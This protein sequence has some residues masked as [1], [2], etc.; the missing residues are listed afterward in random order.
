VT[1]RGRMARLGL[2]LLAV[3]LVATAAAYGAE[4]RATAHSAQTKIAFT[5]PPGPGATWAVGPDGS[6]PTKLS[7]PYRRTRRAELLPVWSPDGR[8]IAFTGYVGTPLGGADYDVYVMDADGGRVRNLTAGRLDAPGNFAWSPD[9][10]RLVL[11]AFDERS[12]KT[13]IH[14][15]AVNGRA[16][17]R[18]TDGNDFAPRWSPDGSTIAF[19]RFGRGEVAGLYA[20]AADGTRLRRLD[21]RAGNQAWSPDG[22]VMAYSSGI[23][24]SVIYLIG[25]DGRTRTRLAR[26]P[27]DA[28]GA[29]AWSPD[30]RKVAYAAHRRRSGWDIYVIGVDGSVRRR[31]TDHRGDEVSPVWSPDGAKIAY[32]RSEVLRAE[33]TGTYDVYLMNSDGSG[34]VR[35]TECRCAGGGGISWQ[36]QIPKP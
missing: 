26:Q 34:T 14:V 1:G 25:A 31:L 22:S 20:V 3:A 11:D 13:R 15:L 7:Q 23:R 27:G 36:P 4:R 16:V 33:N 18:L 29:L 10:E 9:A 19:S 17:R 28:V 6:G 21:A 30:G 12:D 24:P 32:E 35:L 5:G 2:E 8:R